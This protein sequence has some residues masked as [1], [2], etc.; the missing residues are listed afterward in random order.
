[1]TVTVRVPSQLR[2]F[3]DGNATVAL[4]AET[5]GAALEALPRIY[6]R[7]ADEEGA[8]RQHVSLFVNAERVARDASWR[9]TPLSEGDELA[10]I[11]AVSGGSRVTS[12]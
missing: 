1:M 4:D 7:V 11:P 5:V 6:A 8:L 10:I 12:Q 3:T 2:Q 9:A